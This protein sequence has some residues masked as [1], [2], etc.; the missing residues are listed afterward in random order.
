MLL[1]FLAAQVF[2][3]TG[4]LVA[5]TSTD[6][7]RSALQ[8]TTDCPSCLDLL[9]SLKPVAMSGDDALITQLT[10]LCIELKVP[11]LRVN[12]NES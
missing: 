11:I 7:I 10:G 6:G 8:T 3:V 2:L 4:G 1:Y 9:T 12:L 5:A